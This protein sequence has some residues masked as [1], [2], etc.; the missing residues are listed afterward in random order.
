MTGCLAP[1]VLANRVV[2]PSQAMPPNGLE[3]IKAIAGDKCTAIGASPSV[4]TSILDEPERFNHDLSSLKVALIGASTVS[5]VLVK[6]IRDVLGV[7]NVLVGFGLT[8][9]SSAGTITRIVDDQKALDESIG[10]PIPFTE[11]KVVNKVTGQVVPH[12]VDGELYMRGFHIMKKYWHEP[13]R[14]R[15]AIDPNGV[16]FFLHFY[17]LNQQILFL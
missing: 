13:L 5:N 3:L 12:N 11:C 4:Y 9:S 14:N 6:Q 15:D 17:C 16:F 1:I 10:Q 2:M 8:E 7:P